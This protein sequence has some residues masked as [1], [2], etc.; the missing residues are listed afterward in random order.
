MSP[1]DAALG[2]RI[3]EMATLTSFAEIWKLCGLQRTMFLAWALTLPQQTLVR[4]PELLPEWTLTKGSQ[5]SKEEQRKPSN[6]TQPKVS[7]TD[8]LDTL[9]NK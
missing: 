4:V 6:P 1:S 8:A 3:G 2:P 7:L 5:S 9:G